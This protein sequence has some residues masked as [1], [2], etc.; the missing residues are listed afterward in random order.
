MIR[1]ER[2]K[3]GKAMLDCII[4]GAGPAGLT[5]AIY[6]ARFHRSSQVIDGGP[7]RASLIP[8]SHNYP[9]FPPGIAGPELLERLRCQAL[10][11]GATITA[12]QARALRQET[13][14]FCLTLDDGRELEARRVL[15]ATGIEDEL[16]DIPDAAEAIR[17][18]RVRLCAICDG[19]EVN[20]DDVAVYGPAERA[21]RHAV[22]LR[23]F[24][25]RV[26]VIAHGDSQACED[27]LALARHYGIRLVGDRVERLQ[28]AADRRVGM[29]T[30][31]GEQ[32][33]FDVV[34]PALGARVRSDLAR[35]LGARCDEE[36]R[37]FVDAAQCTSVPG[38]YAAGDVVSSLN[39]VSVA[40]GQA[41]QAAT[42]IHNSLE[43][44]PWR[45]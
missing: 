11:F 12:A 42:S 41:A 22:F 37:L 39:Q 7:G 25:D 44:N 16:P 18:T 15:L 45:R 6:L 43:A 5:A 31:K 38:L 19:Y 8:M 10:D 26:T 40:T 32:Y 14:G 21:I 27:A 34:Y 20:G 28:I 4:V 23:T 2:A 9:G 29:R 17:S 1:A 3:G 30:R 13:L 33:W 36:G 35:P 24:T